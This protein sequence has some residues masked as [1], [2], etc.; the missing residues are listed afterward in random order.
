M[1][2]IIPAVKRRSMSAIGKNAYSTMAPVAAD[3]K[4]T[5]VS[6]RM[7]KGQKRDWRE[8]SVSYDDIGLVVNG[9][10]IQPAQVIESILIHQLG[11]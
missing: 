7:T 6:G 2:I 9:G 8:S 11:R 5:R 1:P 4:N 10:G 3:E